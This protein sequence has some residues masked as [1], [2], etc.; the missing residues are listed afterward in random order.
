MRFKKVPFGA[1]LLAI[2][3]ITSVCD[4][5][6]AQL[7]WRRGGS[8]TP[9]QR[10]NPLQQRENMQPS[11]HAGTPAEGRAEFVPNARE[12]DKE[13]R[14]ARRQLKT[15]DAANWQVVLFAVNRYSKEQELSPLSGPY[16][17]MVAVKDH[18][19]SKIGVPEDNIIFLHDNA[20]SD[21]LKP[22]ASNLLAAIDRCVDRSRP[23]S[24]ILIAVACHGISH[25][26]KSF[27]CPSDCIGY[28]FKHVGNGVSLEQY[29]IDNHLV[30]I[31][32]IVDKIVGEKNQSEY[33]LLLVDACR[34]SGN[35]QNALNG[36]HNDFMKEFES[37]RNRIFFQEPNSK[38][39]GLCVLTSCSMQQQAY[40]FPNEDRGVFSKYFIDGLSTGIADYEGIVDGRITLAEAYN[41]ALKMTSLYCGLRRADQTPELLHGAGVYNFTLT[42][43][44]LS[45]GKSNDRDEQFVMRTST[46]L[47]QHATRTVKLPDDSDRRSDDA[48]RKAIKPQVDVYSAAINGFRYVTQ[49][50]PNDAEA[51]LGLSS[52]YLNRYLATDDG[53]TFRYV[54]QLFK[55]SKL[56]DFNAALDAAKDVGQPLLLYIGNPSKIMQ[57]LVKADPD[58]SKKLKENVAEEDQERMRQELVDLLYATEIPLDNSKNVVFYGQKICVTEIEGEKLRVHM[59]DFDTTNTDLGWIHYDYA[60]WKPSNAE[61]YHPKNKFTPEGYYKK[62]SSAV[63]G[64][65]KLHNILAVVDAARS[66]GVPIPSEVSRAL[67]IVDEIRNMSSQQGLRDRIPP[68][69]PIPPIPSTP[70]IIRRWL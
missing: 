14:F 55:R 47:E 58:L 23:G 50:C 35:T 33:K 60:E 68:T 20:A 10:Q 17:D 51:Y 2:V 11:S 43:N 9:Q 32:E 59:V 18:W 65:Q 31:S 27:L 26:G 5:S 22:T 70:P 38:M 16:N 56:D 34:N 57:E 46:F 7:Y 6:F 25:D 49:E 12:M 36:D 48:I 39:K 42:Q 30:P 1:I 21:E 40:E 69:T 64:G 28:D 8:A 52:S 62:Y 4:L 3:F 37:L 29:A 66:F 41:Y 13:S 15:P 19:L 24:R 45:S 53:Q 63:Q 54:G 67:G 61:I 44:D